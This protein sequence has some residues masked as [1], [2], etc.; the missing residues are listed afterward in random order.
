MNK[1]SKPSFHQSASGDKAKTLYKAFFNKV[2]DLYDPEKVKDGLFAAM[3][4]VALIN[5]GPGECSSSFQ[6][7]VLT[8]QQ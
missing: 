1:G 5:D 8:K 6:P 4:D 3:M 2:G 7:S